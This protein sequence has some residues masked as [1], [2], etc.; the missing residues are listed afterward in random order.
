M[1]IKE[2][3]FDVSH[4]TELTCV[5]SFICKTCVYIFYVHAAYISYPGSCSMHHY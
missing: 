4:S 5:E 3:L 1:L 2:D